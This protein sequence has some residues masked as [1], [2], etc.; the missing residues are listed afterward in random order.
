MKPVRVLLVDDEPATG[1]ALEGWLKQRGFEVEFADSPTQ[2]DATLASTD[3]DVILSDI[4]MPGNFKLEWIARRLREECPPPILLMTGDPQLET[5]MRA[6]NLPVA[7]YLLKPLFYEDTAALLERLAADHRRRR[8]LLELSREVTRLVTVAPTDTHATP[9]AQELHR[10]AREL[11]AEAR[12]SP[13]ETIPTDQTAPWRDAVAE[14]IGVLEKTKHSFRSKELGEL[15][16]RL[17]RLV[18][19]YAGENAPPSAS[20]PAAKKIFHDFPTVGA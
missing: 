11:A 2:A 17:Q 14:T 15:R 5:A 10:L 9:L 20:H 8:E 19:V 1:T 7:G 13:R 12:R 16:R 18:P 6:A 3:F 4:Q